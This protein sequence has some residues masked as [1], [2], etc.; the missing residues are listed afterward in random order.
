MAEK[1]GKL[2][3]KALV[4]SCAFIVRV[5]EAPADHGSTNE[6]FRGCSHDDKPVFIEEINK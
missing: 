5:T 4:V 3:L 2:G 6:D 1:F